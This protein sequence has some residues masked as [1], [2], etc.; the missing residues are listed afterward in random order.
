[1][2]VLYNLGILV[3]SAL[4]NLL[5][6]FNSKA[7]LWVEGRKN[8]REKITGKIHPG[9]RTCWFHCSS[10]GEFEQ[11][12]TIIEE[13]KKR[14]PG[15]KIVITFFSPS[16]YEVRK[17]YTGADCILYLP[18]D[19]PSNARDYVEMVKPEFAI[20]IKYEFWNNYITA[21]SNKGITLYIVSAIF[22]AD[23]HFFK[24]YGGFF[25][26]MLKRFT[27]IFVQDELSVRL[28]SGIGIKH[29]KIAGDTRYDRVVQIA[30]AAKDIPKLADFRGEEKMFLAG[31]SWDKDEEIICRYINENPHRMK[32]VFAPHEIDEANIRRLESLLKVSHVR[33]SQYDESSRE[34]RVMIIDNIGMLSSAYRYAYIAAIGGG[35]G[36]G[37]HNVLEAACWG[38]PVMFGPRHLNFREALDLI[39]ENGAIYF[40]SYEKFSGII[41]KWLSDEAYYLKSAKSASLNVNKNTGA[42]AKILGEIF[43]KDMNKGS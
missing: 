31:S 43:P 34:V 9:D 2:K 24:W 19:T 16:G 28:L 26:N 37:I 20:F 15:I 10:L 38:I 27:M 21:V 42:T 32:W 4:A 25:R 3:Y 17:N 35:F 33:F 14:D 8:W 5:A 41:N 1:M 13:I 22:R 30:A 23:Q 12:R 18:T 11:G 7:K 40:D 29:V 39:K 36:K 6:P